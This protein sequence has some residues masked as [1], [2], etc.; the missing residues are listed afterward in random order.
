MPISIL[1]QELG[2]A[3]LLR[4]LVGHAQVDAFEHLGED[5]RSARVFGGAIL[6]EG[7]DVLSMSLITIGRGDLGRKAPLSVGSLAINASQFCL[8]KS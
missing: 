3:R 5:S 1:L 7:L 4:L 2:H 8:T 6:E